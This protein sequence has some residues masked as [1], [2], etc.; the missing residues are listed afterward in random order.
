MIEQLLSSQPGRKGFLDFGSRNN[1]PSKEWPIFLLLHS[2][3]FGWTVIC[4]R[5]GLFCCSWYPPKGWR[6]SRCQKGILTFLLPVGKH[7]HPLPCGSFH[8]RRL[9][10]F[11]RPATAGAWVHA[12]W[13]CYWRRVDPGAQI[14]TQKVLRVGGEVWHADHSAGHFLHLLFLFVL[15]ETPVRATEKRHY[16]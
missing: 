6:F 13:L 2:L 9:G 8:I 7:F 5:Q 3:C 11:V 14:S 16:C 1:T 10:G 15:K 4:P 12:G